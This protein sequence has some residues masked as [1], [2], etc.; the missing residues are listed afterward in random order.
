MKRYAAALTALVCVI[1]LLCAGCMRKTNYLPE[2]SPNAGAAAET[3]KTA[4][5]EPTKEDRSDEREAYIAYLGVL[6][7]ERETR[8]GYDWQRGEIYDVECYETRP[9][10]PT[11]PVV[12]ADVWGDET[13]ELIVASAEEHEGYRY[14]AKLRV[15]T[16]SEEGVRELYDASVDSQVG[17]GSGYRLFQCGTD[18]GLWLYTANYGESMSERY[19]HFTTEGRMKPRLTCAHSTYPD[20]QGND[21]AEW[22]TV[23]NY[24]RDGEICTEEAYR[25]ALPAE[26]EQAKGLLMRNAFYYEYDKDAEKPEDAFDFPQGTAMTCDEAI[27]YLRGK[28][29]ISLGE[30]DEKEFFASLPENYSFASGAGAWSSELS[31]NPDGTFIGSYHDSDM[32]DDGEDYP[33]GTFY[34]CT[35]SGRFGQVKRVDEYT[36]SMR[37]ENLTV[38]PTEAE[39]WIEDGVRYVASVPYGLE[40]ADE[41]LVYLPGACLNDLPYGFRSW[42]AMPNAWSEEDQPAVLPFYGLYNVAEEQGWAGWE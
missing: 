32:G 38:D 6:T 41:V 27:R 18:K 34:I 35:F 20:Y 7:A 1:S 42:V 9:A 4:A 16:W 23:H 8:L 2:T 31:L 24:V 36:Y 30:M 19:V 37:L 25:D 5:P 39:E 29:N 33:N 21:S 40:H 14:A 15:F 12:F 10:A 22:E 17:G 11:T 28:L 13:P 3:P 26:A